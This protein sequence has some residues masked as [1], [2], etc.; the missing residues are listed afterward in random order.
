M[1]LLHTLPE[2]GSSASSD[3]R[4]LRDCREGSQE[5]WETLIRKYRN[6]IYSI[7]IRVGISQEDANEIFQET[8]LSLLAELPRIREPRTLPA[9]LIKVTAHKCSRFRRTCSRFPL[10]F[11]DELLQHAASNDN[12]GGVL[13]EIQRT[14]ILRESIL[15]LA[16][17]CRTLIEKLFFTVPPEPYEAVAQ[18][19]GVPK[20]SIGF[21][22][23]R[24]LSQLRQ[25]LEEKGF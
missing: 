18:S 15:N 25:Q 1:S 2:S 24:C 7:P 6:L 19:L 4:L 11:N 12:P 21:N 17:R 8:C 20:G 13:A 5:A 9:W 3:E 23:M 16:T 10:D 22:R 14:Q